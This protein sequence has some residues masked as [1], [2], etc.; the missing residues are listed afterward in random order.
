MND[1][2][3]TGKNIADPDSWRSRTILIVE[4][5]ELALAYYENALRSV[6]LNVISTM[7]GIKAVEICRGGNIDLVL[8][9]LYLPISDGFTTVKEIRKFNPL[10]PVIAQTSYNDSRERLLSLEAGCNEFIVKP[11]RLDDLLNIIIRYLGSTTDI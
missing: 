2:T 11:V 9:D 5:S 4:D 3:V 10:L 1:T 6:G 7:D 8:L